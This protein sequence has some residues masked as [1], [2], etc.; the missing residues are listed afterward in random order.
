[1]TLPKSV[2]AAVDAGGYFEIEVRN[3][4][5]VLIPVRIQQ[6]DAVRAKR[7]ELIRALTYPRFRLTANEQEELLADYLPY[8]LT[9]IIS[10]PPPATPPCRDQADIPFLQLALAGKADVLVT[11]DKDFLVLAGMFNCRILVADAFL[12]ESAGW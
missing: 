3:G 5:I 9:T 10:N 4:Q 8:C 7:A 11:G 6:A 1:M 2:T 12:A